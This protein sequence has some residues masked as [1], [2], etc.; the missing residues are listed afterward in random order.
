MNT[1]EVV[2]VPKALADVARAWWLAMITGV[3]CIAAGIIVLVQPSISLATLAVIVG[4]FMLIDGIFD[5]LGSLS[6]RED[7]RGM[8]ALLG[9]VTVVVGIILVRHP[10][11]AVVAIALLIGIW[12]V[13]RGLVHFLEAFL[14]RDGRLLMLFVA[15][16]E[17]IA[18]IVIVS[19][20]GIGVATLAILV[21]IAFILR[22]L[23]TCALAWAL[24]ETGKM[25][26]EAPAG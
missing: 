14:I 17:L 12:L 11:S 8:L 3:L 10:T 23:A 25:L 1:T 4:I 24:R 13:A 21:G 2:E 26:R 9:I 6:R 5:L 16:I 18:G 22:G 19:S 7:H 15:V 20:P